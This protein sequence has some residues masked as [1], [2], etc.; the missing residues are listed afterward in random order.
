MCCII[1]IIQEI[2]DKQE[3]I[4][5]SQEMTMFYVSYQG[6]CGL[7]YVNVFVPRDKSDNIRVGYKLK[8]EKG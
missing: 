5:D 8:L 4:K 2:L 6:R 7:N 3:I 1:I